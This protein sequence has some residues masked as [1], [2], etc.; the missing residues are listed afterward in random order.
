MNNFDIHVLNTIMCNKP[1][2]NLFIVHIRATHFFLFDISS[3]SQIIQ[4][5]CNCIKPKGENKINGFQPKKK[6]INL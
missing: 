3:L 5:K 6:S 1:A 4:P 2:Q